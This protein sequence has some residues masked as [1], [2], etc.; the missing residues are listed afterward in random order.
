MQLTETEYKSII[1]NTQLPVQ[2]KEQ[3]RSQ[4]LTE[5]WDFIGTDFS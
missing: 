5:S 4:C 1:G 3:M 2:L